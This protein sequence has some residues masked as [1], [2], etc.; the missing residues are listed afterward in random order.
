MT[1]EYSVLMSVYAKEKPEFFAEA[2]QS[3]LDQT[4]KTNDFVIVCDGPLTDGLE[5][6]LRKYEENFPEIIK[7]IRLPKN[8][9][10]GLALNEGLA[11][12]K[13]DLI[14][15]MDSDDIS[16]PNRCELQL[17]EFEKDD[18]L[19]V[20]GGYITEFTDTPDNPVSQRIVPC[21]NAGI[22]KYA[23]R[24]QPF[25]NVT[26]IYKKSAVLNV[27]AYAGLTRAEDYDLYIRIL[28]ANYYCRNIAEN[29]VNVRIKDKGADRRVSCAAYRGF[30]YTRWRALRS[31][32]SGIWDF[33]IACGAQTAV[34][35]A[36][37]FVQDYMYK[38]VL[39]KSV[40]KVRND[41][42]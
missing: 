23:K 41:K 10:T 35:L 38:K 15:K 2:I 21:D 40:E 19:T 32:Y 20:L 6:V 24:R 29:L 13:N 3:M 11:R 1:L 18:K 9:G 42:E 39:H 16:V 22:R 26:V 33:L 28:K 31:G 27:G 7:A 37:G 25:N 12:C 36:P 8:I 14:A 5:K 34:F 17:K 4:V 30:I